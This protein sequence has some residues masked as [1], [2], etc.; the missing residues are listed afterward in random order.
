MT[1][2]LLHT[3][4]ATS[5]LILFVLLIREPVRKRFGSGV[6]YG[7]WLIPAARLFMPTVT[8][9]V[10]HVVPAPTSFELE[11]SQSLAMAH[12]AAAP[13]SDRAARRVAD[14]LARRLARRRGLPVLEPYHR[15]RARS[16]S[17][18]QIF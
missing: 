11:A 5:G 4:V 17:H 10:E 18:S 12:V 3:L 2:W 15:L 14:Y 8:R 6:A 13:D 9:T 7:L 1:D 16:T